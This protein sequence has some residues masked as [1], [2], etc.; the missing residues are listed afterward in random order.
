MK[1][2]FLFLTL[3]LSPTLLQAEVI[4][5]WGLM[6][7]FAADLQK[8]DPLGDTINQRAK[9][10]VKSMK[11]NHSVCTV[12]VVD[13]RGGGVRHEIW[14]GKHRAVSLT[15]IDLAHPF[16]LQHDWIIPYRKLCG[17]KKTVAIF[18][19][20]GSGWTGTIGGGN[21]KEDT[22][23]IQGLQKALSS[24]RDSIDLLVL[25]I[26]S[27]SSLEVITELHPRVK[28]LIAA[29][30]RLDREG[31]HFRAIT[32]LTPETSTD[33]LAKRI[34]E[35]S[36]QALSKP[37]R[38]DGNLTWLDLSDVNM[39]NKEL[40]SMVLLAKKKRE[41][42]KLTFTDLLLWHDP[43]EEGNPNSDLKNTLDFLLNDPKTPLLL[44]NQ[45][46]ATML[47]LQRVIKQT[48]SQLHGGLSWY[49]PRLIE[50]KKIRLQKNHEQLV[51]AHQK[52]AVAKMIDWENWIK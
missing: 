35:Q 48:T 36:K 22:L 13:T 39:L 2:F 28:Q 8:G 51:A 16:Q 37:N 31:I 47:V 6:A 42:G 5:T 30:S 33:V 24:Y 26:C 3:L 46:H 17:A 23:T 4:P 15:E 9:E 52:L 27:M 21:K 10:L 38:L 29:E 43:F 49:V 32:E 7:L 12:I 40:S 11:G 14:R 18:S 34:L 45:A 25:D 1:R 44:K 41:E 50:G 19:S 20:H